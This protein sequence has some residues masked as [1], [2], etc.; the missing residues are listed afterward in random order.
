MRVNCLSAI[1]DVS[2]A[3][4]HSQA[5]GTKPDG[6]LVDSS[7]PPQCLTHLRLT[8]AVPRSQWQQGAHSWSHGT[9][10]D[11]HFLPISLLRDEHPLQSSRA[12]VGLGVDTEKELSWHSQSRLH[13]SAL[14]EKR[15][16]SSWIC[17]HHLVSK[18][19]KHDFWLVIPL[20]NKAIHNG[21]TVER[22]SYLAW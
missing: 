1:S 12:G 14:G 8:L 18:S 21:G 11:S 10:K 2:A 20:Y 15:Q 5:I 22:E 17:I 16:Y 13:F 6:L 3:L 19:H 9:G 4:C 7:P